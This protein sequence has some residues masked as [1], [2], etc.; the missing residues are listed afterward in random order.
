MYNKLY[1]AIK[2]RKMIFSL[3]D[4]MVLDLD[5]LVKKS[6]MNKI[7]E[8]FDANFLYII[9]QNLNNILN[10]KILCKNYI[11]IQMQFF[12]ILCINNKN[13]AKKYK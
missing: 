2:S 12:Q 4:N 6:F 8:K 7:I 10:S 13:S 11:N 5:I 1:F 3:M 9:H